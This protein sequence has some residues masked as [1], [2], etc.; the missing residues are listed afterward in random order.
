MH[1]MRCHIISLIIKIPVVG[2]KGIATGAGGGG[3]GLWVA[4]ATPTN[5]WCHP[6]PQVPPTKK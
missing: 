1:G 6:R 4:R 5:S 2:C 3:G